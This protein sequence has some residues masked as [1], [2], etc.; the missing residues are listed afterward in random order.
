MQTGKQ[1]QAEVSA[2]Q[3]E[4]MKMYHAASGEYEKAGNLLKTAECLERCP[5]NITAERVK[6]QDKPVAYRK[7]YR[8]IMQKAAELYKEL[9]MQK[10]SSRVL[11]R[12]AEIDQGLAKVS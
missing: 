10:D 6:T 8:P 9:G 4:S 12:I 2:R 11:Q 5:G 1:R 3:L 7:M